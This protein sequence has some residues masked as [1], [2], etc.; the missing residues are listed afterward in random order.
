MNKTNFNIEEQIKKMRGNQATFRRIAQPKHWYFYLNMYVD[1]L[2][3]SIDLARCRL[4]DYKVRDNKDIHEMKIIDRTWK[5]YASIFLD[6][7]STW[8]LI[9]LFLFTSLCK[10]SWHKYQIYYNYL[11]EVFHYYLISLLS[12]LF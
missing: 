12:L 5:V 4:V 1:M 11:I 10:S 3:A 9:F 2:Y 8:I 6:I 7:F